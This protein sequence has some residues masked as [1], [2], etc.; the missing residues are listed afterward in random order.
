MSG[1]STPKS[2]ESF[3]SV[4]EHFELNPVL[5]INSQESLQEKK[6][7]NFKWK[8]WCKSRSKS[9]S[10][11]AR[12]NFLRTLWRSYCH[13]RNKSKVRTAGK[14][15]R[16]WTRERE[17]VAPWRCQKILQRQQIQSSVIEWDRRSKDS[18]NCRKNYE[19]NMLGCKNVQRQVNISQKFR[20]KRK[21]KKNK[22]AVKF[23][24]CIDMISCVHP[25][26][27]LPVHSQLISV[28]FF[29]LFFLLFLTHRLA[30]STQ[31]IHTGLWRKACWPTEHTTP[32]ILHFCMHKKGWTLLKKCYDQHEKQP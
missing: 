32:R 28:K 8:S 1:S 14:R 19:P 16:K 24:T 4:E 12:K 10:R 6:H 26:T 23:A 31:R 29:I 22:T 5:D 27:L 15:K 2:D 25:L 30:P 13:K 9:W 21:R 3:K 11:R 7:Y 18:N 20:K 17:R